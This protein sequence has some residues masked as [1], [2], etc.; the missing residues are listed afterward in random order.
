MNIRNQPAIKS[1]SI[2]GGSGLA[3]LL[4]GLKRFVKRKRRGNAL[5]DGIFSIDRLTAVVTVTDD[6]G[7]SGRLREEFQIL[8]PGDIRKC[9]V[10]LSEDELLMSKLFQYRFSDCRSRNLEHR[11][12]NEA[13]VRARS[14]FHKSTGIPSR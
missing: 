7:S 8:P 1:V 6:G 10:A 14:V 3:R 2:G 9:L 12:C 5:G 4:L 11:L 13:T